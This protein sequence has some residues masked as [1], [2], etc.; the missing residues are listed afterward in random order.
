MNEWKETMLKY[1]R[2]LH[3]NDDLKNSLI[4]SVNEVYNKVMKDGYLMNPSS[5]VLKCKKGR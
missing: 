4:E 2:E 1:I 3:W 5:Y